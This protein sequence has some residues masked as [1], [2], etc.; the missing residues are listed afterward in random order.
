L[1]TALSAKGLTHGVD[2]GASGQVYRADVSERMIT[3]ITD[4]V[5]EDVVLRTHACLL[6]FAGSPACRG[7]VFTLAAS[8]VQ[9]RCPA[10]TLF[11]PRG[12]LG[13]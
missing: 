5:V 6:R 9:L 3:T 10:P 11:L 4:K 1:V 13:R 2:G 8:L 12:R 7:P